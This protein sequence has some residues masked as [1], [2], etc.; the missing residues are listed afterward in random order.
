MLNFLL[1]DY[2]D[3]EVKA[4]TMAKFDLKLIG[5]LDFLSQYIKVS[6]GLAMLMRKGTLNIH[7]VNNIAILTCASKRSLERYDKTYTDSTGIVPPSFFFEKVVMAEE[8]KVPPAQTTV[9]TEYDWDPPR[10]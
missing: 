10:D 9:N 7:V 4:R 5:G 6:D 1:E 8:E 2:G 3:V